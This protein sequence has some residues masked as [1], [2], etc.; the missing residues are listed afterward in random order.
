MCNSQK[1]GLGSPV[2][3][4]ELSFPVY[5]CGEFSP[6]LNNHSPILDLF[7]VVIY[8]FL[9]AEPCKSL[10]AVH[11]SCAIHPN[12]LLCSGFC[13]HI[14]VGGLFLFVKVITGI[15]SSTSTLISCSLKVEIID[16]SSASA[17]KNTPLKLSYVY[18]CTG[19]DSFHL[20]PIGRA[21]SKVCFV[22]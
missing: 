13:S 19:C 22:F 6:N 1:K 11:C 16:C 17:M 21:I 15:K 9:N 8:F 10:Q 5:T 4:G 18:Q 7:L 2:G 14:H 3:I 12:G 20:Q